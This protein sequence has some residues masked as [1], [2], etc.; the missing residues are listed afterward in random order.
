LKLKRLHQI[1]ILYTL[2]P[3]ERI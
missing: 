2:N 1:C 3:L